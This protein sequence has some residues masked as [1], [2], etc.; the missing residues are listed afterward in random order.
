MNAAQADVVFRVAMLTSP[1]GIWK[2]D[3]VRFPGVH[4]LPAE[5]TAKRL[6]K[7]A[8]ATKADYLL[9]I[10]D[11]PLADDKFVNLYLWYEDDGSDPELKDN[12][13]ILFSTWGFDPPLTGELLERALVNVAAQALAT[14]LADAD[15]V[16][17]ARGTIGYFNEERDVAQVTGRLSMGARNRRKLKKQLSNRNLPESLID[18]IEALLELNG[19]PNDFAGAREARA[20]RAD[21][22]AKKQ[23]GAKK[24][25][26]LRRGRHS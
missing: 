22:R 15:P 21:S 6:K 25:R 11:Q 19:P 17:T 10:T 23:V 5:P 13:V 3:N 4:Y 16:D 18:S 26:K 7:L 8:A 12:R 14:L 20:P 2:R 9:C 24:S 1:Y